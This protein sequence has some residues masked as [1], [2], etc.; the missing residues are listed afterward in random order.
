MNT[1]GWDLQG[2]E[3][4]IPDCYARTELW[5]SS[6]RILA[7]GH[8]DKN[9]QLAT[10]G[11]YRFTCNPLYFFNG[12]I[13]VGFCTMAANLWAALLGLALFTLVYRPVVRH[14]AKYM[15]ELFGEQFR[16]WVAAVPL[17]FPTWTNYPPQGRFDWNLVRKHRE[18]RN[19]IAMLVGIVLLALIGWWWGGL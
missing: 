11:P 2:T 14:E 5:C 13:F 9:V 15:E 4:S 8:I 7:S 17:F 16:R 3:V 6:H 12:V 1:L 18:Y 19:A 10:G